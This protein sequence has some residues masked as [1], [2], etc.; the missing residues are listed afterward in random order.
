MKKSV[1][2][3]F[4]II[5]VLILGGIGYYAH[6]S[7]RAASDQLQRN[8]RLCETPKGFKTIP[9]MVLQY[10][11]FTF[12]GPHTIYFADH[13]K[14]EPKSDGIW[15]GNPGSETWVSGQIRHDDRSLDCIQYQS[16]SS[17]IDLE[18]ER[19]THNPVKAPIA[20]NMMFD[21]YWATGELRDIAI[22]SCGTVE[23]SLDGKL[24]MKRK[25]R[26]SS[27]GTSCYWQRLQGEIGDIF[28]RP[29]TV[30][31]GPHAGRQLLFDLDE[32]DGE[33]SEIFGVTFDQA[34]LVE[35]M[36]KNGAGRW[37]R[38]AH[39]RDGR[40]ELSERLTELTIGAM[41]ARVSLS[42]DGKKV[43]IFDEHG[44]G[45]NSDG[46][47]RMYDLPSGHEHFIVRGLHQRMLDMRISPD[48]KYLAVRTDGGLFWRLL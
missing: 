12:I 16:F 14:I 47:L 29:V 39:L 40:L 5:A 7:S 22:D 28:K 1:F 27:H 37:L 48:N 46:D 9:A 3:R 13:G 41:S 33:V 30:T 23:Y 42:L 26:E 32:E 18:S 4:A 6:G 8:L 43:A 15:C 25:G 2:S 34:L 20:L 45:R 10:G 17:L 31:S 38:V 44:Y 19:L 21:R 24:T 35:T 11:F 36:D